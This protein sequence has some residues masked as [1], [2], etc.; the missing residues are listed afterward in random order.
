LDDAYGVRARALEDLTAQPGPDAIDQFVA[1]QMVPESV[2]DATWDT[3]RQIRR[4][5]AAAGGVSISVAPGVVTI[6]FRGPESADV[7]LRLEPETPWRVVEVQI[8]PVTGGDRSGPGVHLDWDSADQ[9]L[10]ALVDEGFSGSVLLVRDGQVVLDKGYGLADRTSGRPVQT[11]IQFD[12]G[13]TPIAFTRAA[14]LLLAQQGRLSLDDALTTHFD[15]V[16]ADKSAITIGQLMTGASGLPNFHHR[17]GDADRDLTFISRQEAVSRILSQELL[18]EPGQGD[19]HSHSAWVLLAAV[20]EQVS[21]LSYDRFLDE[22][23]FAP[24]GMTRTAPYG[25]NPAFHPS[26]QATGYGRSDVGTPNI[27]LNWGPTSWLIMGSGGMVSTPGDL[28]RWHR[29]VRS[30]SVLTGDW[31][32]MLPKAGVTMGGTDRGF[33]NV[34]AFS[35]SQVAIL[36]TNSSDGPDSTSDRVARALINLVQGPE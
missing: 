1:T 26:D 11:D 10:A 4:V 22:Y 32:A 29:Y 17:P 34:I 8:T 12:I 6:G 28:L 25:P 14:V 36:C 20:V 23:F 27:P 30:G 19:S 21:G 24:A 31:L 15:D 35:P 5:G 13:S 16:P 3:L 2:N 18:F 33:L 9:Q 7:T